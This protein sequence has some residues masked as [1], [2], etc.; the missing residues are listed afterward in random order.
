MSTSVAAHSCTQ[1]NALINQLPSDYRP[2][3]FRGISAFGTDPA[4]GDI[5][6][7]QTTP[8]NG[9]FDNFVW[10]LIPSPIALTI[11]K[12]PEIG[13]YAISWPT[14]VDTFDLYTGNDVTNPASWSSVTATPVLVN[15]LW[16]VTIEATNQSQFFRLQRR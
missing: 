1:I 8:W 6:I 9:I 16:T 4:N 3:S 11:S 12:K 5:L 13:L 14:S 7:A 15:D 2:L 10:R